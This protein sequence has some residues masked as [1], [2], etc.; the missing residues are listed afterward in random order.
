APTAAAAP[1]PTAP[2]ATTA[3]PVPLNLYRETTVG[4]LAP[5]VADIPSRVYVP[6]S[7]ENSVSVIDVATLQVVDKFRTDAMPHHVTPSWDMQ[8]LYVLNTAGN[9]ITPIDPRTS[10]PGTPI[11][12]TDPY[13]LYFSPDGSTAI[14]VAERFQRL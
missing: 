14:V 3:T 1:P 8:T 2:P 6:N 10:K 13:N 4:K 5:S 7:E 12:V 11:P 9:T